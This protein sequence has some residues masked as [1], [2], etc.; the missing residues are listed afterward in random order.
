MI[1]LHAAAGGNFTAIAARERAVS[2]RELNHAA[3]AVARYLQAQ[4]FRRGMHA[5][6]TAPRGIEL[7]I[8]LLAVLKAGG[9]YTWNDL[10]SPDAAPVAVSFLVG[11][12]GDE[13]RYL[14]LELA[15]VLPERI[16]TS[17]NLP[18]VTRGSDIACILREQN[19]SADVMVPHATI[20]ALHARTLPHPTPWLGERGAFDLWMALMSGATAVVDDPPATV[21][22]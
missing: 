6:V 3:N 18:V 13:D 7:A 9:S 11:R 12:A 19:G 10:D 20:T 17:P 14:H 5:T 2:Y 15:G 22:A 16:V 4:G 8:V 1:E 21:A